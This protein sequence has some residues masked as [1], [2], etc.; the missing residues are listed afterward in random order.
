MRI[1]Y[2][3]LFPRLSS[4]YPCPRSVRVRHS[5]LHL[6]LDLDP[7]RLSDRIQRVTLSSSQ[8]SGQAAVA[9][10]VMRVLYW[11]AG[12]LP[13]PTDYSQ[14]KA[15]ITLHHR[16]TPPSLVTS[17]CLLT[18]CFSRAELSVGVLDGRAH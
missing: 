12:E 6:L 9:N 4:F 16:M 14:M 18:G 13:E 3:L 7:D 11:T 5:N 15:V 8:G 10:D 2:S 17:R 1:L